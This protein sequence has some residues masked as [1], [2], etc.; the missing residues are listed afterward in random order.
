MIGAEIIMSDN[1]NDNNSIT[2]RDKN[3]SALHRNTKNNLIILL[4]IKTIV[5]RVITANYRNDHDSN[6]NK[7]STRTKTMRAR[8]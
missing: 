1:R 5:I 8:T 3:S 6:D 2:S 7:S 4:L